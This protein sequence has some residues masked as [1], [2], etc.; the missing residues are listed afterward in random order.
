MPRKRDIVP[1]PGVY[2]RS[3]LQGYETCPRR[4]RFDLQT[5]DQTTGY[6]DSTAMIGTV[7]HMVINRILASL[8]RYGHSQMATQEAIEVMY[9]TMA[10]CEFVLDSK[11]ADELRWMVLAFCRHEW[12]TKWIMAAEEL[13]WRDIVC[14][15]GKTR[16]LTGRPDLVMYDGVAG[17]NIIDYKSG[18]AK[19]RTPRV[20]PPEGEPIVGRD[21]LSDRGHFQ[22]DSYGFLALTKWPKAAYARLRELHLRSGEVREAILARDDLEHVERKL[23]ISMQKLDTAIAEG[24]KSPLWRPKPGAQCVRQCPVAKSCPI[25]REQRGIGSIETPAQARDGAWTWQVVTAQKEQ[26]RDALKTYHEETGEYIEMP[27]GRV[28]GWD[29]PIGKGRKF[30]FHWPPNGIPQEQ[31]R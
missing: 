10:D 27:D 12:T 6:T 11:A 29:P 23:G 3:L 21:Y 1:H 28:L 20:L 26:L 13:L 31:Q 17:I 22:L 14:Q 9:E 18:R 25:P 5:G 16:T 4:T 19:P 30:G 2:R 24:P 8:H 7:L 15:D